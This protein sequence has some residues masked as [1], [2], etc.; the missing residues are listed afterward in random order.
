MY[1]LWLCAVIHIVCDYAPQ[2]LRIPALRHK[3]RAWYGMALHSIYAG[4][5]CGLV[6]GI[7]MGHHVAAAVV[8]SVLSH[9]IIDVGMPR[10]KGTLMSLFDQA[11]HIMC[12]A[13]IIYTMEVL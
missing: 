3:H 12:I 8:A 10:R 2:R 7:T 5:P 9:Y 1:I 13:A 6:I 11:V 4:A